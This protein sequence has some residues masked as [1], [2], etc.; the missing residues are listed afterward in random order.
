MPRDPQIQ[1]VI[2][3]VRMKLNQPFIVL[4]GFQKLIRGEGHRAE[5]F[6]RDFR[7]RIQ[8]AYTL[9]GDTNQTEIFVL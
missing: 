8:L 3:V 2:V 4:R 5:T 1:P 6:Q 9:R 7:I